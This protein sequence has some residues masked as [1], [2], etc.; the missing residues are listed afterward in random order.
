MIVTFIVACEIAFWVLIVLGLIAR[1]MLKLRRTS[2]IL[3]YSTPVVDAALLVLTL[4]D[5]LN[6]ATAQFTHGLAAVYIGVSIAYGHSM[7][8]WAD[9]QFAYRF[10]GG[11]KPANRKLYGM[12]HARK[13]IRGWFKH[14]LAWVIGC[15]LIGLIV[16]IV[17][18]G[19]RTDALVATMS[20][21]SFILGID[22]LYSFSYLLWPRKQKVKA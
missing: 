21:W 14:L 20:R 15:A 16:L 2:L 6:G 5:L 10:A 7:I 18:Q 1:Y 19:E 9:K 11:E 12:E 3:L 8:A 17:G 22:F 4:I 13:E